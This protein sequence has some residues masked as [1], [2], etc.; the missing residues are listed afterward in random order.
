MFDRAVLHMDL[1]SFFVSVE[2]LK[3]SDFLGKPLI[4]GGT[5]RRG[6]VASCSYEARRFGVHSAMPIKQALNLCPQA[7]V[8]RGDMDSY[9]Q[10][11]KLVTEVIADD[12]PVY[13]KASIDEFYLDLSGMD[14]HFGCF[15]WSGELR[16]KII[17]ETGLPISFGLSI[18][19][20]VSKVGTG[21]AKP[22]GMKEV[23]N[24]TEKSFLAPL[25]VKKIP[26]VGKET[27]KKLSFM[28]VRQIKVLSEIPIKLLEREFGEHG[29]KLWEKANGIDRSLVVPYSEQKSMSK[30]RTFTEDTLDQRFLRNMLLK[31]VDQLSFELRSKERLT[32]CVTVKLRY[33]DFNTYT[34][35]R[36]IPYTAND[37]VISR[38]ICELF[39]S[40]NERRQLIR[41][42]GIKFSGLVNGSY[43]I[44]LFD[45]TAKAISLMEQKD[46]IR[47]R[48][49]SDKI[50]LASYLNDKAR[51]KPDKRS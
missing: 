28:G 35:Q 42:I 18:N 50:M 27:Y 23:P 7:I 19:K 10:H 22:N 31:M 49:G 41:L 37:T 45:D 1:D 48:F 51:T 14:K 25:S 6:V 33:A 17:R 40:L 46:Y 4:I 11:S 21:E 36:R 3:N 15:K 12:A 43:Q 26:G 9:S 24:G 32:S 2:C 34:K 29:R 5:S 47:N 13:E 44:S 16:Q 38:H 8:L 20:L 39:D 30:E